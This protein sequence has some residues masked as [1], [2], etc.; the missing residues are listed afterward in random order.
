MAEYEPAWPSLEQQLRD[1][2]VIPGSALE[3]LIMDN[4][5]LDMLPPEEANDKHRL[6]PWLRVYWRKAHPDANYTPPSGGYPLLL[7][8]LYEWM[9][10]HQ[11]LPVAKPSGRIPLDNAEIG[12]EH[13]K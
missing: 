2:K 12:G 9:I 4:Q 10:K 11:D 6:P 13:A 1:A 5:D 3:Q 8:E 7:K